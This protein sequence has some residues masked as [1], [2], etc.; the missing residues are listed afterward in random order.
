MRFIL[1]I[2]KGSMTA[3]KFSKNYRA[4][5]LTPPIR[6]EEPVIIANFPGHGKFSLE[7]P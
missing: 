2:L 1:K 4:A 6:L 5:V 3:R 7:P